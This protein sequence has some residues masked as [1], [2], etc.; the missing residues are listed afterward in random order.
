[1][2]SNHVGA[3]YPNSFGYF[4][5]A[6]ADAVPVNAVSNVAVVMG[7]TGTSFL[8]RQAIV[9]NANASAATANVAILT[10]NDGN[11]ANAIF[12]TTAIGNVTGNTK[13][14]FL[15][16]NTSVNTTL[17]TANALWVAVTTIANA[18]VSVNVL[19]DVLV[20]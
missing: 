15:T 20:L 19:G 2:N 13:Y 8:A 14:Q 7:V 5:V 17:V 6:A 10:S 16:A 18:T 12:T 9:Y 3:E 1:M 4:S 11:L